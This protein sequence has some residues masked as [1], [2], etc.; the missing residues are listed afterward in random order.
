MSNNNIG[1]KVKWMSRDN[2]GKFISGSKHSIKWLLEINENDTIIGLTH[3]ITA[4]NMYMF[5]ILIRRV[6]CNNKV[7]YETTLFDQKEWSYQFEYLETTIAVT[8]K[9]E[10][11]HCFIIFI[12]S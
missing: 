5:S 8:M 11:I 6:F 10:K 12:Y 9:K 2:V 1:I 7:V 4:K 3:S